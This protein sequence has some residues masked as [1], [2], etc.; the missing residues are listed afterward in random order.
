MTISETTGRKY[1]GR[2][3]PRRCK[4]RKNERSGV[5]VKKKRS[6]VLDDGLGF[7]AES[8]D[9]DIDDAESVDGDCFNAESDDGDIGDA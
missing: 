9:G 5:S 7:I 8:V 1:R 2:E 3:H 4:R 6:G